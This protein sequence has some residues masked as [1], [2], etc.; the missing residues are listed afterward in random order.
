MSRAA[1]T[2]VVGQVK[3]SYYV[4]AAINGYTVSRGPDGS[5][6]LRGT[7]VISDA[8]KMAQRPLTFVA[9]VRLGKP[10]DDTPTEW[11]WPIVSSEIVNGTIVARLG[12]PD[13]G[14]QPRI[15]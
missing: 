4:A 12:P 8:F 2:G 3:W 14:T 1:I 7:I 10:P 9:P 15:Q 11:R 5:W 13:D 6:S